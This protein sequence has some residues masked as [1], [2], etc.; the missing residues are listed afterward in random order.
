[1]QVAGKNII[2][3]KFLTILFVLIFRVRLELVKIERSII[4]HSAPFGMDKWINSSS[5]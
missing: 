5:A 3:K 4:P 2:M 1:M